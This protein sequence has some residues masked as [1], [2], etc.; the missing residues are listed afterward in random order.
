MTT[1]KVKGR[2]DTCIALRMPVIV[3]AA[4]AIAMAD[5]ILIDRGIN[6]ERNI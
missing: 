6:G 5:L 4:T 2:H 3:E 1:L